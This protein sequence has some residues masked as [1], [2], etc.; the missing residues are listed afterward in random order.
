MLRRIHVA[1]VCPSSAR[2]F[3]ASQ[4]ASSG[5]LRAMRLSRR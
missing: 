4:G 2:A 3:G 1:A 5:T